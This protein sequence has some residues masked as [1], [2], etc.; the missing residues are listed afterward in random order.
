MKCFEVEQI[1]ENIFFGAGWHKNLSRFLGAQP[2]HVQVKSSSHC[3]PG[4]LV[5]FDP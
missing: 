1:E 4:E 3:F 5:S 2:D